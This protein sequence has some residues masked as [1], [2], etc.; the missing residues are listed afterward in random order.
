MRSHCVR[1]VERNSY[2]MSRFGLLYRSSSFPIMQHRCCIISFLHRTRHYYRSARFVARE[3]FFAFLRALGKIR[4]RESND[5]A[6]IEEKIQIAILGRSTYAVLCPLI[7]RPRG[8][9]SVRRTNHPS[10]VGRMHLLGGSRNYIPTINNK[11][12]RVI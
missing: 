2:G 12:S 8:F 6:A 1:Q 7:D 11:P 4:K 9:E 5:R 3:V 10:I